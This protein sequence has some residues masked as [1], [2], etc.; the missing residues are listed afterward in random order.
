MQSLKP[1]GAKKAQVPFLSTVS[2]NFVE[3]IDEEYWW[4]NV[5]KPVNL[6]GAMQ[7]IH[8]Q[9]QPD[10]FIEVSPHITLRSPT[11]DF[12]NAVEAP[13][14][15]Y[16][17]T[18]VK[19]TNAA[20]SFAKALGRAF[21]ASNI[22]DFKA[23]FPRPKP[24]TDMFPPYY[25]K[26]ERMIDDYLDEG[27]L[28]RMNCYSDGPFLGRHLQC[29]GYHFQNMVSKA[30]YPWMADHV[31]QGQPLVPAAGY[32]ELIMEAFEGQ[33]IHIHTARF[34]HPCLLYTSPSPRDQRG[35]RM[36]SSA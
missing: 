16:V 32:V 6:L 21:K 8:E 24:I 25:M 28:L 33:P 5:R 7:V 12:Y 20:E 36:P 15:P 13:M 17:F 26:Q 14:P 23:T 34:L 22:L 29:D 11:R 2:G 1:L 31:V 35:S 10:V 30:H 3:T 19:K 4:L 18:L 27:A 9:V